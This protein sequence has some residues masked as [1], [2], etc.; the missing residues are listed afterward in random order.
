MTDWAGDWRKLGAI[1]GLPAGAM[2]AA[3]LLPPLARAV[4]W[5]LALTWMGVACVANARRC[6]RTHCRYTGPFFLVMAGLVVAYAA[7]VLPMGTHG[8]MILGVTALVGNAVIWWASE[9]IL[10]RFAHTKSAPPD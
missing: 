4:I 9:R 5:T 10:G 2:L 3:A 6:S 1:W 8:W 7:G